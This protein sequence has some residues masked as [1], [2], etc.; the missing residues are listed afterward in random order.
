MASCQPATLARDLR[1]L[2]DGGYVLERVTPIDQFLYS[3]HLEAVAVLS[4]K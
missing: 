2:I 3:S 4:R 1:T